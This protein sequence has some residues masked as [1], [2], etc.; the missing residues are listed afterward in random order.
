MCRIIYNFVRWG[1]RFYN[2]LV[3]R[4]YILWGDLGDPHLFEELLE[5]GQLVLPVLPL[6]EPHVESEP[7]R[8]GGAGR[9]GDADEGWDPMPEWRYYGMERGR[10]VPGPQKPLAGSREQSRS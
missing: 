7:L 10:A 5:G 9:E 3:N 6:Q 1:N 4:C 2:R 8:R